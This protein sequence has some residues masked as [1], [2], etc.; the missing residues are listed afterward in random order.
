MKALYIVFALFF[1]LSSF[2]VFG[3]NYNMANGNIS[4]CSGNFFDSGGSGNNYNNNQNFT[5][6]ICPSTPGARISVAFTSFNTESNYDYLYV[7]DGNSTGATLIGTYTGTG[8]P[9]T[10]TASTTNPTG[11]LTF[12]FTSDGSITRAGWAATISCI[13]PC[14]TITANFLSSNPAPQ[15]DGIIRVCQGQSVTFSGSG[16]FSNSGTGATYSW[17]MGNGTNVNGATANYSFPAGGAYSV[18]LNITDPS[19]CTNSNSL[20]RIVQVSTTPTLTSS[21]SPTTICQG[22]TA[23]LTAGVTMTPFIQNCTPPVSGTT[24]LPDGSGAS[25]NTAINVNCFSSTQTVQSASD[26]QNVCITMEHS[27]LGDLQLKLICPNGQSMILKAYPGGGGT[28]LGCPLDDGGTNPGTGRTYCFTPTAS[29]LLVNGST[30][31]CGSPSSGS[32]VAGNYQPVQSFNNLIGCP[33][34]GSWTINV[35]DNLAAD[36]GYIFGWDVNFNPSLA[37]ASGSFTPTIASQGWQ[38]TPG[39][40]STGTTTATVAPTTLGSN[41]YTYSITDNFGCTYNR[42][43]CVTVTTGTTPTFT[44]LGPFCQGGTPG[45]LPTTSTNGISGTWSPASISTTS[46]GSTVYTFTPNSGQCAGPTTM[47]VMVNPAPTVSIASQTIC[48]GASTTLVATANPTGGTYSWSP[49]GATTSSITVNPTTTTSYTVTYNLSGCGAV[50]ATG[51]VTVNP[52]ATVSVNSVTICS[53][54][55]TTLT[56][57]PTE[58]GGTYSWSSSATTASITVNPLS[59]TTYS[60]TYTL[61]S[62]TPS[63]GTGTVTVNPAPTVIVNPITICSG[64]TNTLTATV[65]ESGGTYSWAPGGQ[66]TSSISVN[67]TTTTTYSVTY[68][69]GACT[70]ATGNAVVTVNPAPTVTVNPIT[71]CSGETNTLIATVSESGGTYSWSPGGQTTSSISVNPTS[72]TTYSVTY[73]LGACTPATGNAVVTVNP[74]PTVTVNPITICSG[75]TNTLTA[76]VSESGGTYSWSPGGQTTSSISVNPTSTTT[77]SVTYSLGACTPATGNAVATVNPA[78]T[79]TVNPITICSGETNTLTATVSESGGT[80]SWSLG[81]QTTSSI[82]VNPTT[83]TTYSVTYSLGA[84]TPATGNAVV[85]VNPAPTVT[86]NPI[87]ICNGETNTLTATVSESGGTYSWAPGGQ[88]TSSISVNPTTN[89]VY[90]VSYSLGACTVA[91]A[92]STVTVNPIPVI[93]ISN[94]TI[95]SGNSATLNANSVPSG[96]SYVWSTNETNSSISVNPTQT[97]TY[98]VTYTSNNCNA[99]QPVTVT[100]N[101][102]P[103]INIA[104]QTICAGESATLSAIATPAGGSYTWSNGSTSSSLTVSPTTNITYNVL[105]MLNGCNATASGSVTVNP[106]PTVSLANTTICAGQTATLIPSSPL[107]N[108]TYLWTTGATSSTLSVNPN[109]TSIYGVVYT[110]NNCNSVPVSAS[111]TVTPLPIVTVNNPSICIGNTATLTASAT[112]TG[113]TYNWQPISSSTSSVQVS[114]TENTS[115]NL[116]YTQNNCSSIPVTAS[117]TVIPRPVVNFNA[118]KLAGCLPHTVVF[119]NLTT[120][121]SSIQNCTWSIGNLGQF[122]SCDSLVYTFNTP[123]C[124]TITLNASSNGCSSSQTLNNYI[125]TEAV[126]D[127]NFFPTPIEFTEPSQSVSFINTSS[128]ASQY[129]WEFSNGYTSSDNSPNVYF[130]NTMEGQTITLTAT[131]SLGCTDAYSIFIPYKEPTIFYI[132]NSFTPDGDGFNQTFKPVFT[133]GFDPYNFEMTIFNRWGEVVFVSFNAD[134]GWDGSFGKTG[135]DAPEGTYIYKITYK[136]PQQDERKM[137][138]GHITM[139][140]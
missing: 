81:G 94:Q 131:N 134:R 3:Q 55:S 31:N 105:Y 130:P 33:L 65:S 77:Y 116:V 83:T 14:Q 115:Y 93:T 54:E 50:N 126:P 43:Q 91:I 133:S 51:T 62:C 86:V 56:A 26:I 46:P 82:S 80:Y 85:T 8:L 20:N 96:G 23:N 36:N 52:S 60:V 129:S 121:S 88:T 39:L 72:T 1:S 111:V 66:T 125:C 24:F 37:P 45:S 13:L 70:P 22:Q 28:Y 78:P 92:N 120:S 7:Y 101:P 68:S 9:G 137:V 6:T 84:C 110:V 117:V 107:T 10:L 61:G 79:V 113:G 122:S 106:I 25:Y 42:T 97:T 32:I 29:T 53:G 98:S 38:A 21:A 112:P 69:L 138:S 59:T 12:R 90:T 4:T 47:T 139:I 124:F 16:T 99:S 63:I 136:I 57:T 87:T 49:G 128:N 67:P 58:F 18:N 118:D 108:G 44:Q 74:A 34:N 17:S 41:C 100:V 64:E 15:A 114:P 89:S 35:I 73:S 95:C 76:T 123:G 19:G 5:Y 135:L 104:N 75:E 40:T 102:T 27:Y 11:C 30:S 109:A 119:Q 2:W 140:R 71:I 132:P 127:A 103:T 48:S